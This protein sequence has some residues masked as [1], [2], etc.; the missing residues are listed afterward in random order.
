MSLR[1][2]K[3][4]SYYKR[5][6][7]SSFSRYIRTRDSLLTTKSLE[8]CKCVTC[9]KEV[10][11]AKIQ[12]GHAIGGRNN[13]ILF[14]EELVH[15]QCQFCNGYGGGKYAQ[16]SLWFIKNYGL[17][18]WKEKVRLSKQVKRYSKQDYIDVYEEYTDKLNELL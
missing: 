16:Y 17:D 10:P 4:L 11:F 12:A 15:G 14:D 8:R 13:S 18:R 7:W 5:K 1:K 6:A 2:N 9:S 3:K